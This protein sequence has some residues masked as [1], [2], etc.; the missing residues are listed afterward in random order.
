MVSSAIAIAALG[1]WHGINPGMGWL[2]AVALGLQ[3][4]RARAVWR[5]LPPLA[6]GHAIAVGAA[7]AVALT[8]EAVIDPTV[9]RL[10]VAASL[11]VLG[12]SR[13]VRARHPRYGGMLV[14]PADL[15]VWSALMASAH[16][17]GLM[18]VPFATGVTTAHA[19]AM[20]GM[21]MTVAPANWSPAVEAASLHT[22]AYLVTTAIVA[23]LVYSRVGLRILRTHWINL[24]LIWSGALIL[25]A[26]V[27]ALV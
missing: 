23:L 8:L 3:E 21:T 13:F 24:D 4:G 18:L 14:G 17:A 20:A 11:F 27:T 9:V 2:F 19:H 6:L 5:A 22:I 16:G 15:T 25:T 7:L 26:I 10:G 1:V 12:V